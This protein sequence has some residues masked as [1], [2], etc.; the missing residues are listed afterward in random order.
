VLAGAGNVSFIADMGCIMRLAPIALLLGLLLIAGGVACHVVNAQRPPA[1]AE[2]RDEAEGV[3]ADRGPEPALRR[4]EPETGSRERSLAAPAP[5]AEAAL[6][7][8]LIQKMQTAR[9]AFNHPSVLYLTRRAQIT[10]TLAADDRAAL[11]TLQKQFDQA[12]EGTVQTGTTKVTPVMTATLVG[13]AFRIEPTGEQARAVLLKR[14]GPAEWTWFVEPT[15]PGQGRLLR[16]QP[17]CERRRARP[18][19]GTDTHQD[20]RGA[21]R[22]RCPGVGPRSLRGAPHDPDLAGLDR[23]RG[24]RGVRRVPGDRIPLAEA[25]TNASRPGPRPRRGDDRSRGGRCGRGNQVCRLWS[26]GPALAR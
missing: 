11:E 15:E 5:T 8:R 24:P 12:V 9:F 3:K 4:S 23:A 2:V 1:M 6:H 20:L 18:A 13:R 17:L 26:A 21:H 10:L 16:A 22:R 7:D 25:V 19:H 14:A